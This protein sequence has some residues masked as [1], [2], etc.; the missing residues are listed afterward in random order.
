LG[1]TGIVIIG[2]S[3]LN[4]HEVACACG[5]IFSRPVVLMKLGPLDADRVADLRPCLDRV[6]DP[7]VR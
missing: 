3:K 2:V 5:C 1:G 7:R 6:P 4:D